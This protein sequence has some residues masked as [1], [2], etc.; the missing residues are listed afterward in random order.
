MKPCLAGL[1]DT[2]PRTD[3]KT[4]ARIDL[5]MPFSHQSHLKRRHWTRRVSDKTPLR[6]H[7]CPCHSSELWR[8]RSNP[9]RVRVLAALPMAT[10][11]PATGT[12][13]PKGRKHKQGCCRPCESPLQRTRG[14]KELQQGGQRPLGTPVYRIPEVSEVPY[15]LRLCTLLLQPHKRICALR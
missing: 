10:T 14:K 11:P 13:L 6:S 4:C 2:I 3:G 8:G 5:K 1:G 12:A 9:G 15:L 7:V